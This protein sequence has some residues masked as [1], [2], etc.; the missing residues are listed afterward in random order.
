MPLD[1]FPCSRA[2]LAGVKDRR[3]PGTQRRNFDIQSEGQAE[4]P[5]P[6]FLMIPHLSNVHATTLQ[7]RLRSQCAADFA[8][9][10]CR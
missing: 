5:I 9:H 7:A 1:E 3:R 10:E 4:Q 8:L 2:G 6:K